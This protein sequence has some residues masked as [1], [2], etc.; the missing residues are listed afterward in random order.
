MPSEK[1]DVVVIGAGPAG[2]LSAIEV[3]SSGHQVL[4][5]EEH[6]EVGIPDHCAGLLSH[7]GL[8]MLRL[9]PPD[10]VIL[11]HVSGARIYSPTGHSILIERG[12]KEAMVIDRRVFDSW[13]AD[14]AHDEGAL[15]RT[16]SRVVDV[17]LSGDGLTVSIRGSKDRLISEV[18]I[19]GE[20]STGVI[21]RQLGFQPV[22]HHAKHVAYQYEMRGLS[23]DDDIVEMFYGRQF[24]PGFFSWLIPLGD[25]RARV[26]LAAR[27]RAK[28]RLRAALSHHPIMRERMRGGKIERGMGGVVLIGRP[29]R[30]TYSNRA[31][32]VGDAAGMVKATTGGGVILGGV[33][34]K[35]AGRVVSRAIN[36]KNTSSEFLKQYQRE[37]RARFGNE[38]MIMYLVQRILASLTDR[39]LDQLVIDAEQ[40][41]LVDIVRRRGDMDKQRR[42]I[43]SLLRNPHTIL[44]GM[45]AIRFLSPLL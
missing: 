14:K 2:L 37:W 28:I 40:H 26:G 42:V 7:S 22:S 29:L 9:R 20:G 15:V 33:I 21:S 10:D 31:L 45:R 18:I 27:D 39:G 41:G 5:L 30:R 25:G 36:E 13:L 4:V 32:L 6:D 11:N 17:H 43:L 23:I 12:K 38:F 16:G 3:A 35:I 8:R 24:A 44:M 34:S 1:H 19:N